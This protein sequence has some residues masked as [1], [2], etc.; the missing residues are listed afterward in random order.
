MPT[1][2]WMSR[3]LTAHLPR[4]ENYSLEKQSDGKTAVVRTS[5][6][7]TRAFC[8]ARGTP[9]SL[10]LFNDTI[11]FPESRDSGWDVVACALVDGSLPTLI[12]DKDG[13]LL[14]A[15]YYHQQLRLMNT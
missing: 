12:A 9:T 4:Y 10:I 11:L 8:L 7:E 1:A 13:R 3:Q 15:Q 2:A 6:S 14:A 5:D